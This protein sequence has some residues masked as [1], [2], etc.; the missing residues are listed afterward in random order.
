MPR[1]PF[2]ALFVALVVAT[3]R[4][5]ARVATRS[6]LRTR[7]DGHRRLDAVRRGGMRIALGSARLRAPERP[8]H[9]ARARPAARA[10]QAKIGV[11][12]TNPGGPG[13]SG[14][15]FLRDAPSVFP[16][17]DPRSRSTSSPGIRAASARARRCSASTT[18][19]RSTPSTAIRTTA[20]GVAQNVAASQRVRRGVREE[21][22]R[23][24]PVPVDR[25]TRARDMDAI[26]AAIGEEQITLRRLLVRHA[27]RRAV[28]RPVP[29]ARAGD[30]ARRPDRP[31]PFVRRQHAST[32]RRAS[33]TTSTRSSQHC[34]AELV[35]RVRARQRSC[36]C[37][38]GPRDSRSRRS[39]SRAPS[40]ASSA[41]SAPAS[42]TS[43]SRAR[44]TRA[45]TATAPLASALAQAAGGDAAEML[46]LSDD[47]HR[48][49]ARREVLERDRGALRDRVHR[50]ARAA[51]RRRGAA[52]SRDSAEAVA[53]WFGAS[54]V[55][56]GLPCTLW[57]VAAVG[58][59]AP[60]HA[61]DAPPI[62]VVGALY[63][64]ATPYAWAQA[65]ATELDSRPSRHRGR[66]EPH[67]V[68]PRQRVRRPARR[69]RT[70]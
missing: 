24:P 14:V 39:P 15:E 69:R 56:L 70:Y 32:R 51:H 4:V 52:I 66:H 23:D 20:A 8:A 16:D 29:D 38:R 67:V 63:D 2:A 49:R 54:T 41:R 68:R 45:P 5:L 11:L 34:Q 65:L 42:S 43:G 3:A 28:R 25:R 26:R 57:P 30:G 10:R 62:V 13:G 48:P 1:R 36:G 60:I 9:H 46:A 18:S 47:V 50:R 35:V 22:R 61:A 31:R 44:C 33:T 12:F 37:V 58:K 59:V 19:T 7:D 21:Q 55:W 6:S 53:P 27:A 64:P 40:T 17:R